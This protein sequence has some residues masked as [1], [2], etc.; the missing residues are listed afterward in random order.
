MVVAAELEPFDLY[1]ATVHI[2][3]RI[4]EARIGDQARRRFHLVAAVVRSAR[5]LPLF[6]CMLGIGKAGIDAPGIGD[7]RAEAELNAFVQCLASVYDGALV[8]RRI[9]IA[10]D[11]VLFLHVIDGHFVVCF[12]RKPSQPHFVV[13]DDDWLQIEQGLGGDLRAVCVAFATAPEYLAFGRRAERVAVIRKAGEHLAE[14]VGCT[15]LR[16]PMAVI[17]LGAGRVAIEAPPRKASGNALRSSGNAA[18]EV[19]IIV[20]LHVVVANTANQPQLIGWRN[21]AMDVGGNA[22]EGDVVV[23]YLYRCDTLIVGVGSPRH[24]VAGTGNTNRILVARARADIEIESDNDSCPHRFEI[25]AVFAEKTEGLVLRGVL[26]W[27]VAHH[28]ARNDL[29]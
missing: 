17:H 7:G 27:V 1:A 26:D 2:P 21:F 4:A 12:A 5:E 24:I 14:L 19:V 25:M 15:E 20:I 6:V 22:A 9:L 29:H 23:V 3:W 16:P 11:V 18:T 28:P 8:G 10:E 13:V